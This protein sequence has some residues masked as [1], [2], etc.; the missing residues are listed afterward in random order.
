MGIGVPV[1]ANLVIKKGR[2]QDPHAKAAPAQACRQL[3]AYGKHDEILA[4][5]SF[6]SFFSIWARK[7]SPEGQ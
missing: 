1:E 2:V 3:C 4:V 7:L 6:I 5:I